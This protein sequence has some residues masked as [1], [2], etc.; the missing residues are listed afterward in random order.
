MEGK[1]LNGGKISETTGEVS[2]L[3]LGFQNG[4]QDYRVAL[5]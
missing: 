3:F 5:A 2:M 1:E 4:G